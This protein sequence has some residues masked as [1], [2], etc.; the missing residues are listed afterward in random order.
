MLKINTKKALFILSGLV[1][2]AIAVTFGRTY[3]AHAAKA[4]QKFGD[5]SVV[6]E[7][8]NKKD[9]CFLS[10]GI[11]AKDEKNKD[12]VLPIAEFRIGYFAGSK[13]LKML[14]IL[15][16]DMSLQAGTN[17]IINKDKIIAPG[18]FT[19]CKPFGCVAVAGLG[20]V[21]EDVYSAT[22]DLF[23]AMINSEG[24]QVNIPFSNKGLKEGLEALK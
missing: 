6:C 18:K 19:V 20:E 8:E 10:Q 11:T 15:P 3:N 1:L 23:I 12:K 2:I 21:I 17:I 4:G 5:W 24:K 13:E 16:F 9:V 22:G 14:Q 7:K